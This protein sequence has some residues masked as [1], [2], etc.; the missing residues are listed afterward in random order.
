MKEEQRLR[1]GLE[2]GFS[3]LQ[4]VWASQLEAG[5]WHLREAGGEEAEGLALVGGERRS[6]AVKVSWYAAAGGA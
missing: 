6:V 5:S 1:V 4:Q 2:G 3:S